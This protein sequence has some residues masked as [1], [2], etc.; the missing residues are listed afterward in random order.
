[1]PIA[2]IRLLDF[3]NALIELVRQATLHERQ[4]RFG[5]L[6]GPFA[7]VLLGN[8]EGPIFISGSQHIKNVAHTLGG[9]TEDRC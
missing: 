8:I 9:K 4:A 6:Y 5:S 2:R 1:M 7:P 3:S